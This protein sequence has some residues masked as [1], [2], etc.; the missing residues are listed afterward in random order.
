V[1]D[2]QCQRD[3]VLLAGVVVD[4]LEECC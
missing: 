3:L 1:A 4:M 2:G